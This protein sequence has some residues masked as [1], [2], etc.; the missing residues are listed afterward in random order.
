MHAGG[1]GRRHD[2]GERD[3]GLDSAKEFLLTALGAAT[4]AGV[5]IVGGLNPPRLR[6]QA[7]PLPAFEVA[8]IK[9]NK[10]EDGGKFNTIGFTVRMLLQDAYGVQ[11][12]QI[13]GGPAWLSSE[14]YNIEAKAAENVS[15]EQ[16]RLMLQSLLADRF[17][18]KLHRETIFPTTSS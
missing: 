6:A 11:D 12:F 10:A 5:V 14:R 18:V 3:F 7:A 1:L 9:P 13:T 15:R 17:Q 16:V 4:I 8:S 2:F